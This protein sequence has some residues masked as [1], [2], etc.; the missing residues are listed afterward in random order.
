MI[1][2]FKNPFSTSSVSNEVDT[3][4]STNRNHFSKK[5]WRLLIP[6]VSKST[7]SPQRSTPSAP[8]RETSERSGR[9]NAA[10]FQGRKKVCRSVAGRKHCSRR[11]ALPD[12]S[13]SCRCRWIS[14][15][16]S[17]IARSRRRTACNC[18]AVPVRNSCRISEGSLLSLLSLER[19]RS[20]ARLLYFAFMRSL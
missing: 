4:G 10:T 20:K 19:A 8:R 1:P 7:L 12:Y 15:A 9:P 5:S 18:L 2:F 16:T 17:S 11:G 13:S 6:N 3:C 14:M